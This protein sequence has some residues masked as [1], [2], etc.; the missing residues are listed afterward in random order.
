MFP[1]HNSSRLRQSRYRRRKL[2]TK[3]H[4]TIQS[5]KLTHPTTVNSSII[6]RFYDILKDL[7]R[8]GTRFLTYTIT[9]LEPICQQLA[10]QQMSSTVLVTEYCP[11]LCTFCQS[12]IY[13]PITLYCGHTFCDQCIKHDQSLS[14]INCP[15]CPDNIQGQIHSPILQAR[16]QSYCK[17]RF[18]TELFEQSETFKT[19]CEMALLCHK[20]QIEDS[21]GNHEKAIEIY[22]QLIDQGKIV[23]LFC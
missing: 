20:G 1:T 23:Y 12:F 15:R 22:S 21:N 19:T 8:P 7:K 14:T 13:E 6:N 16:E 5:T 17:N 10:L 18:L 2:R 11:F 3:Q 4:Q 9:E